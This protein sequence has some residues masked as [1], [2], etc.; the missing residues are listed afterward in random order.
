MLYT[1]LFSFA[2]VTLFMGAVIVIAFAF[3]G[4]ME[5]IGKL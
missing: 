5:W 3:A 1:I 2:K 4:L